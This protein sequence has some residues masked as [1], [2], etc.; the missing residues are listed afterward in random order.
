MAM[1]QALGVAALI[2]RRFLD[3]NSAITAMTTGINAT[4]PLIA[5]RDSTGMGKFAPSATRIATPN[6]DARKAATRN[7]IVVLVFGEI[8]VRCATMAAMP[9]CAAI[10]KIARAKTTK[11]VLRLRQA[12]R[13]RSS[14]C[15]FELTESACDAKRLA[16]DP[17]GIGRRKKNRGGRDV[18]CLPDPAER[19]LRFYGFTKCFEETACKDTFS[20]DHTGINRIDPAAS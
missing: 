15:I 17:A 3:A 14:G 8:E 6:H 9:V 10:M 13:E 11:A 2:A 4:N 19:W 7:G 5:C 16:G 12:G 18:L 1:S 20:L